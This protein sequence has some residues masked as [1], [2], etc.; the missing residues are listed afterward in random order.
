M[1]GK[2]WVE[3]QLSL[4]RTEKTIVTLLQGGKSFGKVACLLI[5]IP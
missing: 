1:G 3:N 5:K 4:I 2:L